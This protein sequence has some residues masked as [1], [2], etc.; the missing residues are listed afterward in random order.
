MKVCT[1]RLTD[2]P[3][4]PDKR[5]LPAGFRRCGACFG[6][7]RSRFIASG[8]GCPLCRGTGMETRPDEWIVAGEDMQSARL[9]AGVPLADEA[10]RLGIP[11]SVLIAMEAGLVDPLTAQGGL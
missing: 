1:P 11:P 9:R 7:A 2:G 4:D 6:R 3:A 10:A 5:A 8:V